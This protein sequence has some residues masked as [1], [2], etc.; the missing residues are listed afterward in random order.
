MT[1]REIIKRYLPRPHHIHGLRVLGVFGD[2]LR[3]PNLWHLNR[4]SVATA[5]AIGL[6]CA[7]LPMPFET[8]PA[9][10]AALLMRAN[11]PISVALVWVSNPLT[12]VPMWGP[13]Y[14]LG[15]WLLGESAIP[16]HR[17]AM[18]GLSQHLYALWLGC[19]LVGTAVALTGYVAVQLLWRIKVRQLWRARRLRRLRIDRD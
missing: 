3:D 12:W 13:A 15:I 6:F 2:K 9:A 1:P 11:L 17:I 7:Y 14:L 16:F 18:A 10:A 5:V 8:L 4:R 19:L